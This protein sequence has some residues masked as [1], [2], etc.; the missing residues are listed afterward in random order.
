VEDQ[1][2]LRRK[3]AEQR[4]LFERERDEVSKRLERWY[5][6]SETESDIG[7]PSASASSRRSATR[8]C[9]PAPLANLKPM[10]FVPLYLYK[11][12]TIRSLREAILGVT[13]PQRA[14]ICKISATTSSSRKT[15]SSLR[16]L[17]P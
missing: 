13:G 17:S 15:N 1:G 11:P 3:T 12:E 16:Q 8:S 4:R 6:R 7:A 2:I 10:H 9:A 5:E 14:S